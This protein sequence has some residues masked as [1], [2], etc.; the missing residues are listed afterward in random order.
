MLGYRSIKQPG[1]R[2]EARGRISPSSTGSTVEVRIGL[3]RQMTLYNG[4]IGCAVAL[5]F[6]LM[7]EWLIAGVLIGVSCISTGI[8][9]GFDAAM[10]LENEEAG[11][12]TRCLEH[13][14]QAVPTPRLVSARMQ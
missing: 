5:P 3:N 11:Y 13:A 2:A 9:Q 4:I 14:T 7:A 12:L 1:P 6:V 10:T 8:N